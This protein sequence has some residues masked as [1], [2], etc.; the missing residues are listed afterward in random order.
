MSL[1][2]TTKK[3]IDEYYLIKEELTKLVLKRD[4]LINVIIPNIEAEYQLK[5]G[6]LE[7]EKFQITV[8]IN[9]MK[10]TI[11]IIQAHLNRN[12]KITIPEID[13]KIAKEFKKWQLQLSEKLEKLEKAK[14]RKTSMLS[15]E[16]S[17]E[18][19]KCYRKLAKK[20]HP[21]INP[22]NYDKNK[23]LWIRAVESYKNGDLESLKT[24]VIIVED[25]EEDNIDENF[26][27]KRV[28]EIKKSIEKIISEINEIKSNIPYTFIEKLDDKSWINEKQESLKSEILKLREYKEEIEKIYEN[29]LEKVVLDS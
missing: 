29:Y 19:L 22:E 15:K 17:N 14:S 5:L 7:Y 27:E 3:T 26:F 23:D 25:L 28:S 2:K 1:I 21:D 18:I 11:E 6:Q 12:E 8:E 13:S 10:R 24:L 20:L 16:E 9:K 4:N